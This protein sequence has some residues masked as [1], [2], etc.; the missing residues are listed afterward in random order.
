M[1]TMNSLLLGSAAGLISVAGAQAADL[2]V[3]A[4]PV[5]YV[6]ICS[7][8]GVG[9]YY[10]PGT[11]MCLKIG[12]WVRAEYTWGANGKYRHR[13][14]PAVLTSTTARPTTA[15]GVRAATSRPM[16]A[17]R[18]NTARC[19]A[20]SPSASAAATSTVPATR[21]MPTAPSSSGPASPSV[22]RSRSTT[23]TA[24]LRR[25]TGAR[26]RRLTPVIRAG[27]CSAIRLSSA[28]ASRQRSPPKCAA[29]RRSSTWARRQP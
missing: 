17:T 10:I 26:S 16:R 22:R 24:C 5:E 9:F 7:L 27:K 11:D 28:M 15:R 23:S 4:K 19:V 12:G 1:K 25:R 18:P 2:P 13:C 6:K 21:S 20:I 14:V 29:L 3:K 8:Y